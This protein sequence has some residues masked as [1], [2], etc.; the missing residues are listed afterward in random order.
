LDTDEA[1]LAFIANNITGKITKQERREVAGFVGG[2]V[3]EHNRVVDLML[4]DW[5]TLR[6]VMQG[7]T[8]NDKEFNF[9]D[10]ERGA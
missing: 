6:T 5:E 3:D 9:S 1:L 8:Q 10:D 7:Y 4:S 2:L